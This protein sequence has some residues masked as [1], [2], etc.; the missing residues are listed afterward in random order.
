MVPKVSI[1]MLNYRMRYGFANAS[2]AHGHHDTKV[3]AADA[4][5]L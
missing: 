4:A 5:Y 2:S 3:S 1:R